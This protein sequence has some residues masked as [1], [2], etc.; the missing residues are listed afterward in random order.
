[1]CAH[2]PLAEAGHT[3]PEGEPLKFSEQCIV[4]PLHHPTSA[5]PALL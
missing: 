2:I 4:T 1:M 3:C 5:G